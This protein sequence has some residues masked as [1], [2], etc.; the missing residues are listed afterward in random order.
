MKW[1]VRWRSDWSVLSLTPYRVA[2]S[3]GSTR[4]V[5]SSDTVSPWFTLGADPFATTSSRSFELVPIQN[6]PFPTVA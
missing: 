4:S 5:P 1:P 6:A 2:K 3:T